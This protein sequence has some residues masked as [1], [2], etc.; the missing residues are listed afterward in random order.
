VRRRRGRGRIE[1]YLLQ[2]AFDVLLY[3][4]AAGVVA[5][6]WTACQSI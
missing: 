1:E 4:A 6:G 2:V 3:V 5:I